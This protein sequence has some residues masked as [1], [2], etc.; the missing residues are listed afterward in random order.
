[1]ISIF[2][3]ECI[4]NSLKHHINPSHSILAM[5]IA[6]DMSGPKK[7][8]FR[9]HSYPECMRMFALNVVFFLYNS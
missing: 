7:S 6:R 8:A 3:A 4:V 9:E 2:G 1:M 5:S